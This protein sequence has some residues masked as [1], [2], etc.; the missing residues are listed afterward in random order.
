MSENECKTDVSFDKLSNIVK[1]LSD[2]D[3]KSIS[4]KGLKLV[5][6]IGEVAEALLSYNK[7]SSCAYK[8][9]SLDDLKEEL[10]DVLNCV[11]DVTFASGI[12]AEDL[13]A[14]AMDKCINK[15]E[16]NIKREKRQI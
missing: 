3:E 1:K 14:S 15:W 8:G 10:G 13:I 11:L 16:P 5:E 7:V 4:E 2:A 6:E 12:G 9:K